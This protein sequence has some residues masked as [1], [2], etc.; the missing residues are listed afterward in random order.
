MDV[1]TNSK[2]HRP[3]RSPKTPK[4]APKV[5]GVGKEAQ[6]NERSR[7]GEGSEV[8]EVPMV[9]DVVVKKKRGRKPKPKPLLEETKKG[10][11]RRGPRVHAGGR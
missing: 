9:M 5:T 2:Q 6:D 3:S 4:T 10:K 1:D 7:V 8:D 11:K